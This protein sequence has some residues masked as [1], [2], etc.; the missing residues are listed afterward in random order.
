M[1][2]D[3]FDFTFQPSVDKPIVD[4]LALGDWIRRKENVLLFG[5][6]GVGKT[7]LA[8]ALGVRAIELGYSVAYYTVDE[9]LQY[10]K[11]RQD[12]PVNRQRRSGYVKNALLILDELGYQAMDRRETHLF[13]Q[14][15]SARYTKGSTIVTSNRSASEWVDIFGGDELATTALLDRLFHRAHLFNID[16][17][18]YRLKD[19]DQ[20]LAQRIQLT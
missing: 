12:T 17:R 3:N 18:S 8:V 6:P 20:A 15:I 9:V 10:L 7:H 11:K 5:Q 13:F 2:L 19:Y 16:G 1:T 4:H 14:L